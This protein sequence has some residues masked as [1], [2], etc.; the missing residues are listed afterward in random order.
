M[1]SVES[2]HSQKLSIGLLPAARV[3]VCEIWASPNGS[4]NPLSVPSAMALAP[5]CGRVPS[6]TGGGTAWSMVQ[7]ESPLS[8]PPL[9]IASCGSEHDSVRKFEHAETPAL[10]PHALLAVTRQENGW[11]VVSGWFWG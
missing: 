6:T 5:E 1:L 11:N 7:P 9:V 10:P 4:P 2:G 3:T 8:N